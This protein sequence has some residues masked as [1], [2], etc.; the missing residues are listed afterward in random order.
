M[1]HGFIGRGDHFKWHT[2]KVH[3]PEDIKVVCPSAPMISTAN[4]ICKMGIG[5]RRKYV[6]SW[7][8]VNC[9]EILDKN[10]TKVWGLLDRE[11]R[12][13]GGDSS[14]VFICGHSQGCDL[15]VSSGLM[16]G[17]KLG[18]IIGLQGGVNHIKW[19]ET[20]ENAETPVMFL[21]GSKDETIITND[22]KIQLTE[23]KMFER[24]DFTWEVMPIGH[25]NVPEQFERI[26]A[27]MEKIS[28]STQDPKPNIPLVNNPKPN[29]PTFKGLVI[30]SEGNT[31][32][33][34]FPFNPNNLTDD[35]VMIKVNSGI[36]NLSDIDFLKGDFPTEKSF[37]TIAGFEGSGT[38]VH[39]GK[40]AQDILEKN[41]C[42]TASDPESTG[43]FADYAL[44]KSSNCIALPEKVDL[45]KAAG[46]S[47][48]PATMYALIDT[49][50][51]NLL[52]SQELVLIHT[53]A[54]GGIGKNLITYCN[55]NNVKLIN[56]EKNQENVD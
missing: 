6:H 46:Y 9:W 55:Q 22:V 48:N 24:K 16:Y 26:I 10:F 23:R 17:K 37:P 47:R 20:K 12:L 11:I 54:A 18:G 4:M 35:H 34:D 3:I 14:K 2:K 29:S 50:K 13:L 15:A 8:S 36:I 41:V 38:V 42:F 25:I 30:D 33:K 52:N 40:N 43:S 39:A 27:W 44:V 56:I 1:L 19:P 45:E 49:A 32:Y 53:G 7:S 51:A 5:N 21:M 31:E 28:P